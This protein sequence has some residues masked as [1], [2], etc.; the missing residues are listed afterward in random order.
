MDVSKYIMMSTDEIVDFKVKR[1]YDE[2]FLKIKP[3]TVLGED[4]LG[5]QDK[6]KNSWNKIKCI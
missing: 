6:Q 2:L 5:N 1:S 4:N 3:K